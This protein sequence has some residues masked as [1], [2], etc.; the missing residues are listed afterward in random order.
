M[1]DLLKSM[2]RSFPMALILAILSF[3]IFANISLGICVCNPEIVT[4][5]TT[6]YSVARA[7]KSSC[8][9]FLLSVDSLFLHL[10]ET[11]LMSCFE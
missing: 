4:L 1:E 6:F 11:L 8:V 5:G 2:I 3:L 9:Y 10:S 7:W